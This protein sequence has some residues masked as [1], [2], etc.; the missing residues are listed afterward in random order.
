MDFGDKGADMPAVNPFALIPDGSAWIVLTQGM[1]GLPG[2]SSPPPPGTFVASF[3]G[4]TD[5]V[6]PAAGDYAIADIT[7]LVAAL[8]AKQAASSVLSSLAGLTITSNTL[9][10]GNGAGT[11]ATT[12]FTAFARTLLDDADAA[13]MRTTLDLPNTFLSLTGGTLTGTLVITSESLMVTTINEGSIHVAGGP[14]GDNSSIVG[15]TI[16]AVTGNFSGLVTASGGVTSLPSP[17]ASSDA[18][19]KSYVDTLITGLKWKASARVATTANGTLATAFANGQTVDGVTLATGDRILLK[20]QTTAT[21]NGI[22]TVNASGAPT[23]AT[24]ADTGT[25]LF[26]AVLFIDAGT[27]SA[28]KSYRC[29][30]ATVPTIG[31]TNITFADFNSVTGALI[32]ANNLS[33]VLNQSTA[34]DN[35]GLTIGTNVQA[36][37]ATL[38]AVVAGTY[39]GAASITLAGGFPAPASSS[40]M[41]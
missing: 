17:T 3:N 20:N 30:N 24:D 33:D 25:E 12:P 19:T 38:A 2:G 6:M 9:A 34:R 28:G 1:R 32:A 5:T 31:S 14:I 4:R 18:A 36:Y 27:A 7:G 37:S 29:T 8:A 35:L 22:Y 10:Y 40:P 26:S 41:S 21:Q 13:A 15:G 23:R 16:T 11:F 39:T